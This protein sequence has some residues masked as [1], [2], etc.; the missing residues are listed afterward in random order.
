MIYAVNSSSFL[1]L[2]AVVVSEASSAPYSSCCSLLAQHPRLRH[3][4][5]GSSSSSSS[6]TV[7]SALLKV[8]SAFCQRL[9]G[10]PK[11]YLSIGSDGTLP[12]QLLKEEKRRRKTEV[13]LSRRR[14]KKAQQTMV[15]LLCLIR[16]RTIHYQR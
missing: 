8:C 16:T 2:R 6:S 12:T 10:S 11:V 14:K 4:G 13:L 1:R 9:R 3:L 15:R 7:D 5:L